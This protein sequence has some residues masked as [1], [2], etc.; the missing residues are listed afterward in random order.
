MISLSRALYKDTDILILDEATNAL[1][2]ISEKKV[3][4]KIKEISKD[5]IIFLVSHNLENIKQCSQ[6][7]LLDR[8]TLNKQE[9]FQEMIENNKEIIE[10]F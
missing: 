8:N 6:I 1:D 9:S 10:W 7:F 3:F 4:Q 2:N 5:K